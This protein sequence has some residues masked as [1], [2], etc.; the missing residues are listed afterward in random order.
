MVREVCLNKLN[1]I[2]DQ[3]AY[4]FIC[5]ASFEKRCLSVASNITKENILCSLVFYNKDN[6]AYMEENISILRGLL[7]EHA[8]LIPLSKADPIFTADE[9]KRAL[10]KIS[11]NEQIHHILLDITTFTHESLL[12]ILKLLELIFSK[13]KLTC[14]Y[15]NA[16]EYD[17]GKDRGN[18]W[19][20]KGLVEIRSVL[21]YSGNLLPTQKTHL[22][23]I[24]G[25]EYERAVNII[26]FIEPSSVSLGFGTSDNATTE[27][28]SDANEHYKNLVEAVARNY[29]QI[30][31]FEMPCNNPFSAAETIIKKIDEIK[32]RNILIVP[33]NNK[34]STIGV[35][36]AASKREN[37]QICYAPATVYNYT[38]YSIPGNVCYIFDIN[39]IS[40]VSE[41][42][43]C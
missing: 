6:E 19:L 4:L 17:P 9:M 36:L 20:S 11:K 43:N 26:N 2:L 35:A 1:N 12:L 29:A 13:V 28:D 16:K 3:D 14:L 41:N 23:I 5:S 32:D 8:N 24:V 38:N 37:V 34:L 42:E 25:Y 18:K 39:N 15:S 30:D 22:I 40:G 31:C 33:L 7:G 10:K 27:K 21:G